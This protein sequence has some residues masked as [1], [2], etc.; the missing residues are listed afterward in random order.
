MQAQGVD[1][2]LYRQLPNYPFVII[3]DSVVTQPPVITDSIFDETSRG[4]HFRVNRTELLSDDPFIS[5]YNDTIVPFIKK[6]N[7]ILRKV[8]VKGAASPEGPYA[9]NV[10]L[11]QGRTKRL[12]EFLNSNLDQPIEGTPLSSDCITED[13]AYLVKLM[14]QAGDPEY[15]KV[16]EL[17][18]KCNGDERLCKQ[19]LMAMNKGITWRRLLKVYFPTLRQSRVI[20]WF[21]KNPDYITPKTYSFTSETKMPEVGIIPFQSEL[22]GLDLETKQYTR[23]H[24]IA[25]RTN[26][27]HDCLFIPQFGFAPGVNV[28]LEYYPL[29]GHYTYNMGFTFT[30]H[31]HWDVH[32]F[33]QVREFQLELRRYF[34]GE[35]AFIG[36]YI[37]AYADGA[38]YG[39][40]FSETKGWEGE[41]GGAGLGVGYTCNLTKKGNL[42]LEFSL[43]AG[44]FITRYDPYVWGNPINGTIDGL[45]Y[46]D[47]HGNASQF[48]ERNHRLIW[49]GPTNAGIH[50]TYDIIYRKRKEVIK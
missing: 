29:S 47:Y 48:K 24:M 18:E 26:L 25:L 42:R 44:V 9:N 46:Y 2:L 32:R 1:S 17:W 15:N 13:Y 8:F 50:L 33:F 20:L 3:S 30:N 14:E 40:G 49:F 12:L 21:S 36:H 11:S 41:G 22:K 27:L 39:I 31:R 28:Q 5:L 23:R 45:Y 10:R 19:K 35:G 6:N 34:K 38:K 43:T 16:K 37:C 7:L 4:I